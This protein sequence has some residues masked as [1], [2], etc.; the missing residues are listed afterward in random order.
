MLP[1]LVVSVWGIRLAFLLDLELHEGR[2]QAASVTI[3]FPD[4]PT[5]IDAQGAVVDKSLLEVSLVIFS[6]RGPLDVRKLWHEAPLQVIGSLDWT[7]SPQIP[8]REPPSTPGPGSLVG[9]PQ[10]WWCW[11]ICASGM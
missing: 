5:V 4:V 8:A 10:P 6:L 7:Q 9:F 1:I 11:Q 3:M 2:N